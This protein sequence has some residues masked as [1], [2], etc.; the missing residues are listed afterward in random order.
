M[1][2]R[3]RQRAPVTV[4]G[5]A[6]VLLLVSCAHAPSTP[7]ARPTRPVVVADAALV[8]GDADRRFAIDAAAFSLYQVDA[9]RLA[10]QRA[11]APMVKGYAALLAQQHGAALAELDVLLRQRGAPWVGGLPAERRSV[12]D[13]LQALAPEVFDRRFVE[14]IGVADH[15]AAVLLFEPAVRTL[16]D[17]AL[18]GWAERMLPWLHNHLA[19]ARQMPPRMQAS[20]PFGGAPALPTGPTPVPPPGLMPVSD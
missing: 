8:L 20:L 7:P 14:Q 17:A 16:Q 12:I 4:A 2:R 3:R 13:A 9:A 19:M 10:E 18:R 11:T 5:A 1:A 6:L 15:Q